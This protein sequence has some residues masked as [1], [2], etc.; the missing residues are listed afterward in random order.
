M[1]KEGIENLIKKAESLEKGEAEQIE[2]SDPDYKSIED[3]RAECKERARW[4]IGKYHAIAAMMKPEAAKIVLTDPEI[5]KGIDKL[6]TVLE[7]Y[8]TTG[9]LPQWVKKLLDYEE[10]FT[11]GLWFAG[12][13]YG[14]YQVDQ[15]IK[16][17][18]EKQKNEQ[19]N[20]EDE[21]TA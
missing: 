18:K 14:L 10:I 7:K 4:M 5:E 13:T 8:P 16:A 2:K 20:G 12:T 1:S 3:I 19:E 21:V 15:A 6:T 17:E 11:C 9:E